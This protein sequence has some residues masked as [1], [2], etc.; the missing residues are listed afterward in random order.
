[1]IHKLS[2]DCLF[3]G[4]VEY[5]KISELLQSIQE[6]VREEPHINVI[7]DLSRV[8][9]LTSIHLSCLLQLRDML[10][11]NGKKLILCNV[12]FQIKCE[13]TVC[14]LREV[15]EFAEDKFSAVETLQISKG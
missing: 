2:D 14:D 13:F 7:V 4:L 6:L 5:S 12:P 15:F 9:L 8:P 3:V 11:Q 1:M 10:V